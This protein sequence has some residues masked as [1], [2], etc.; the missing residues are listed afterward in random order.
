MYAVATKKSCELGIT[1]KEN[2]MNERSIFKILALGFSVATFL[3][4]LFHSRIE[5]VIA[6]G[7]IAVV[8]AILGNLEK[9]D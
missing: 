7:F 2:V 1:R 6:D 4:A 8:I 5:F 9:E 3:S